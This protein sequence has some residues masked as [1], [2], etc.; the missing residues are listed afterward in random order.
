MGQFVGNQAFDVVVQ[1]CSLVEHGFGGEGGGGGVLHAAEDEVVHENL[2]VAAVRVGDANPPGEEVDHFGCASQAAARVLFAPLGCVVVDV[3]PS[4]RRAFFQFGE[5]AAHQGHQ[6][7]RMRQVEHVVPA[8]AAVGQV[9]LVS[10]IAVGED[11]DAGRDGTED[12]A[13]GLFDRKIDAGPVEARVVILTLAPAFQRVVGMG[14][15]GPDEVETPARLA[16]VVDDQGEAR[17]A[18]EGPAQ[19][20]A[21]ALTIVIDSRHRLS[22]DTD[23]LD[24]HV[25]GV[26]FD[27]VQPILARRQG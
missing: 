22:V 5:G 3:N 12:L 2:A 1:G 19:F 9:A 4:L 25:H 10:E 24:G 27:L 6:I 8:G 26:Q 21:Q 20:D 14:L 17:A 16:A 23:L 11:G 13:G 18:R 15:V 7:W